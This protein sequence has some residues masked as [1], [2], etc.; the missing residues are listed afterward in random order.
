MMKIF[1]SETHERHSPAFE[2][3]EGGVRTIYLEIPERAKRILSALNE[4]GWAEVAPPLDFGLEPI[5]AVHDHDYVDFLAAAWNEWLV[6]EPDVLPGSERSVLL[7]A[8]F[9][10]KGQHH[11]PASLLG[12][13]GYYMMDLS[14][15]IVE[16]TYAAALASANCALSAAASV[17]SGERTAFSLGRPP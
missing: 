11:R 2:V 16:G 15:P 8:T 13:A 1:Y 3:F 12:K 7:P 17:D 4:A 10:L 5:L 6:T 9:A 14:A